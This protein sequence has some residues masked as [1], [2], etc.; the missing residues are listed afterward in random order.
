MQCFERFKLV[1]CFSPVSKLSDFTKLFFVEPNALYI[2]IGSV[3]LQQYNNKLHPVAYFSKRYV[4][5]ERNYAPHDKELLAIFKA[6][7]EQRCY[8]DGH[9]TMEFTSHKLLANLQ[10]Q[11][12]LLKGQGRWL[13]QLN[14]FRPTI[15]YKPSPLQVVEDVLLQKAQTKQLYLSDGEKSL[16]SQQIHYN[17]PQ[18][19][20]K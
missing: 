3:L 19:S 5:S 2:A 7:Q 11:L 8:L 18:C 12:Y 13:E 20:V 17:A 1:L 10:T 6:C 16:A 4:F 14:K 9:Q 15:V